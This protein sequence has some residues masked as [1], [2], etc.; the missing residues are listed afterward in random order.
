[1]LKLKSWLKRND[2]DLVRYFLP[3]TSSKLAKTRCA[4]TTATASLGIGA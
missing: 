4:T 1:M 2:V 3:R